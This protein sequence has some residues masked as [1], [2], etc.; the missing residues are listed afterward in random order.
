MKPILPQAAVSRGKNEGRLHMPPAGVAEVF[1]ELSRI[2][3]VIGIK[4][5]EVKFCLEVGSSKGSPINRT[6][7]VVAGSG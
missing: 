3:S 2:K 1:A 6:P 4:W 7:K 5:P